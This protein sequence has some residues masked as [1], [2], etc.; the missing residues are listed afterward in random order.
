M[1]R[2]LLFLAG[3]P[4]ATLIAGSAMAADLARPAPVYK[5]PPAPLV[6]NWTGI[7]IGGDGGYGWGKSSGTASFGGLGGPYN[8]DVQGGI[9]GG[10]IGGNYQFN[11]VVVGLEGDWQWA[12]VTGSQVAVT[13]FGIAPGGSISSKVSNY[14]SLRGRL[15][16]AF[17][18]V[19]LF[20]TGGWAWGNTSSTYTTPGAALSFIN[21]GNTT[22][23]W[24]GGAGVEYAFTDW[25]IGRVEYRY[26]S[27]TASSFTTTTGIAD[28]GNKITISDIRAGISVK[29]GP[30]PVAA[31]Y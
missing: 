26:T 23:G 19:L 16:V 15:G 21:S 4:L 8:F 18:R 25:V 12:D 17:D 1:K 3:C 9:A 27:L 11:M 5:T 13:G 30:G 6:Y 31:A 10:F 20:G 22:D 14:G 2:R 7:Y 24:T 29:F 28:A